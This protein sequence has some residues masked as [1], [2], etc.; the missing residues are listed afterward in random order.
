[1]RNN[2][3]VKNTKHFTLL[4]CYIAT[5][6]HCYIATL[7][8]YTLRIDTLRIDQTICSSFMPRDPFMRMAVFSSVWF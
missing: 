1:M 8:H 6:L 5:L 4:H 7:I 3:E 2:L